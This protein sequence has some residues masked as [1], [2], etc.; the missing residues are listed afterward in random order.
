MAKLVKTHDLLWAHLIFNPKNI[1]EIEEFFSSEFS[2]KC[3]LKTVFWKRNSQC[4]HFHCQ[5]TQ[6]DRPLRKSNF[7]PAF[8]IKPSLLGALNQF[9]CYLHPLNRLL[10]TEINPNLKKKNITHHRKLVEIFKKIL[11]LIY[12]W[13]WNLI[14]FM[15]SK[16]T[17][18]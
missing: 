17:N 10:T 5:L 18:W 15:L 1:F 4:A 2:K 12:I 6:L 7:P 16:I 14:F 13:P 9:W 11:K 8:P 3:Y